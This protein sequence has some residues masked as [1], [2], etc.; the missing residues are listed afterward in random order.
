MAPFTAAPAAWSFVGLGGLGRAFAVRV[1]APRA[2]VFLRATLVFVFRAVFLG[3]FRAVFFVV[4]FGA[5]F[6]AVFFRV[7][8]LAMSAL[9]SKAGAVAGVGSSFHAY[10]S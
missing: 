5:A 6:R 3:A 10:K 4:R 1:A 7:T 9:S 8:R 2:A